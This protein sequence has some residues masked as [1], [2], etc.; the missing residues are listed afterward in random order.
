MTERTGGRDVTGALMRK[1]MKVT[2]LAFLTVF[3]LAP[4]V[5]AHG[6]F[7]AMEIGPPLAASTMLGVASYWFVMLWPPKRWVRGRN[8]PVRRRKSRAKLS[9]VRETRS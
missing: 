2:A 3:T 7:D 6:Q 5:Y 1:L 8:A 4:A 9:L